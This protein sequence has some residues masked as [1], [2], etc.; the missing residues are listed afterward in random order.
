MILHCNRFV[1]FSCCVLT[2]AGSLLLEKPSLVHAG[3]GC[4]KPP[5]PKA[6][7]RPHVAYAG[8]EVH[9]FSP[10]I[11]TGKEYT[12]TFAPSV[13]GQPVSVQTTA[14]FQRD[15]ADSKYKPQ[16]SVQVPA[17]P[18]GP[19][20]VRV[21]S[22]A[23]GDDVLAIADSAFTVAPQP[24]TIPAAA[25]EYRLPGFRAAVSRTG[26]FYV[27]LDLSSVTLPLTFQVQAKDYPVRFTADEVLFY[28]TQGFLMQLLD[29][30]MPG[31]F[32]ILSSTSS[33]D[34]DLLR[35]SRHEFS[36]Y[37]LQHAE[38]QP[39]ALDLSDPNWHLDGT[40]HVDHNHLIVALQ[41]TL[42]G[43]T[44]MPGATPPFELV[45]QTSSFFAH[46]LVGLSSIELDTD[47]GTDSY[48]LTDGFYGSQGDIRSNGTILLRKKTDVNGNATA[49]EIEL[50]DDATVTGTTEITSDPI[51][52]LP[53]LVP[54]R[55]TDLSKFTVPGGKNRTLGPGSYR[56]TEFTV[57]GSGRLFVDNS[58][59]P[60][61]LYVTGDV[62]I[63][64][65]GQITVADPNPEKFA[66]Y[67]T[68]GKVTI[69][70]DGDFHGV[71]Y[72]PQ[73]ALTLSGGGDF[74]GA[75]V[76]NTVKLTGGAA[77][78]YDPTL[79]GE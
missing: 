51:Q 79:R 9:I 55:I 49:S 12:I 44:P 78:H 70:G 33:G 34:S 66:V 15:L 72:A 41:G 36:T 31:L 61:T 18:L 7:I 25:G 16:L 48:R 47:R 60:V 35:Y 4:D 30:T 50:R 45:L 37:Y 71:V 52:F 67:V 76:G 63:S 1:F 46:G 43:I 38:R 68:S 56:T 77:V 32:S 27:S 21:R 11:R 57:S 65:G 69:S 62:T 6:A 54:Q 29:E 17:L 2:L 58:R 13:N 24:V 19:T 28:N 20:S 5:P 39:H 59:G 22:T 74:F 53:I 73:S 3:C 64:G 8:G 14:V 75:F 26:V 40:P 10:E 23:Q 42:N